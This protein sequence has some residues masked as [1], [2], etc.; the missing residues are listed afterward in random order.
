MDAE[1]TASFIV[2]KKAIVSMPTYHKLLWTDKVHADAAAATASVHRGS[3]MH[4]DLIAEIVS[5]PTYHKPF[6]T[7]GVRAD[8]TAA[9]TLL[10]RVSYKNREHTNDTGDKGVPGTKSFETESCLVEFSEFTLFQFSGMVGWQNADFDKQKHG[11]NKEHAFRSS[12]Q[13][14][15]EA[16]ALALDDS[17]PTDEIGPDITEGKY[18]NLDDGKYEKTKNVKTWE[19]RTITAEISSEHI[20]EI[21]KRKIE[22][23]TGIPTDNQQ[24]VARGRVLMDDIPLKEYGLS[25][26]ETIEMTAKL[27]GGMKHK[28]LSPKPMNT[29]RERKKRKESEP[30][31]DVGGFDDESPEIN[32]DEEPTDT[33]K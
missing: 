4:H 12:R 23:N 8:T 11:K 24:L 1:N 22:A 31:I 33:K 5:M 9:D 7:G 13:Q 16:Q 2:Q 15:R 28:S 20:T 10:H 19:G 26:G 29:E 3:F 30:C 32:P 6:W 18:K 17:V 14:Q 27:L 25:G 21:V